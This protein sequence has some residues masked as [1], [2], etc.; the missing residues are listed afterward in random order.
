VKLD[1]R[2]EL[3]DGV[4]TLEALRVALGAEVS[5]RADANRS[6][7][8]RGLE[9]YGERL[10]ALRLEWLE[11]PTTEPLTEV[12]GVPIALDESL[13]RTAGVPDLA[14]RPFVAALVLKPTALGGISRCL[15]LGRHART[16]GRFA[17]ASHTLEGPLGF[18]AAATLALTFGPACAHGLAPHAALRG[19][20]PPGLRAERDEIVAWQ[21]HGYGLG[22]EESLRGAIVTREHRR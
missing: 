22:V 3:E 19:E 10:R 5:L 12:L 16:L 13:E 1:A 18:M 8:L 17:C 20:R 9:P 14:Q 4:R 7:S 6:A 15:E 2:R 21:A 11:E